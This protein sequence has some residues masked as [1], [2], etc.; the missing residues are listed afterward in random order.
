MLAEAGECTHALNLTTYIPHDYALIFSAQPGI[1][2]VPYLITPF[3]GTMM[4]LKTTS[5]LQAQNPPDSKSTFLVIYPR[6]QF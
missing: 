6:E 1:T 3:I 4:A 5:K 2:S